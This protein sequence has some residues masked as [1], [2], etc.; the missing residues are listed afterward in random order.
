[1]LGFVGSCYKEIITWKPL[2]IWASYGLIIWQILLGS[3]LSHKCAYWLL[4]FNKKE[5]SINWSGVSTNIRIWKFV[6]KIC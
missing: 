6:I 1:M 2:D 4:L 5:L 3:I